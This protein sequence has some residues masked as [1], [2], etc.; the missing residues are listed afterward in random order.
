V[1][2][3][4]EPLRTIREKCALFLNDRVCNLLDD[5][6]DALFELADEASNTR[7]QHMYFDAMR[8]CLNLESI[9]KR[10]SDAFSAGF[11]GSVATS[12]TVLTAECSR[13]KMKLLESEALE[14]LVAL[15]GLAKKGERRFLHE[16]WILCIAWQ[17]SSND[18]VVV[19]KY[20]P[21]GPSKIAAALGWACQGLDVDIKLGWCCSNCLIARLFAAIASFTRP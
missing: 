15:E 16:V 3:L 12:L 13:A 1:V 4:P 5:V 8:V 11:Q 6:D 19:A 20:L 18:P 21:M 2:V 17:H 7:E 14:E 9:E 10:F